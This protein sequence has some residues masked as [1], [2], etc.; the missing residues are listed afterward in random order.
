MEHENPE[1]IL[2]P[3]L[4]NIPLKNI[5]IHARIGKQLYKGGSQFRSF[6]R[7]TENTKQIVI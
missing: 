7:C 1:E 3:D 4:I 6:E 2:A 5:A